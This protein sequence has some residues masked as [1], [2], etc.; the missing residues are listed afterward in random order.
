MTAT[1]EV[2][3][4]SHTPAS[5]DRQRLVDTPVEE[6]LVSAYKIPTDAPESDGTYKWRSTTLI[7]V[8]AHA[9]NRRG[10]GYTYANV[11]TAELIR[12]TLIEVVRGCDAMDVPAIWAGM[13]HAIRNV[14]R[15]GI[16]SMAISAVDAALWDLK[17]R[18][19]NVPLVKLLGAGAARFLYTAAV[20]SLRIPL[21]AFKNSSAVGPVKASAG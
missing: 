18:L 20:V 2:R 19:L 17:A 7:V 15:P 12:E 11:A 1:V 10:L 6:V 3:P 4:Q 8:E 14:G 5:D 9:G 16:S 13:V 21:S